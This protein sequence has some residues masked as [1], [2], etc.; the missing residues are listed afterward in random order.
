MIKD[1]EEKQARIR[2]RNAKKKRQ[3]PPSFMV[4][5]EDN[6]DKHHHHEQIEKVEN[7]TQEA[8]SVVRTKKFWSIDGTQA[9][10]ELPKRP[11]KLEIW[12]NRKINLKEFDRINY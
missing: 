1:E 5:K 12:K 11:K 10:Q 4:K 9:G 8:T 6:H 3:G 7:S 2:R